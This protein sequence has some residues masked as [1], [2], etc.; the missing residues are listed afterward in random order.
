MN[1]S[2]ATIADLL[3]EISGIHGAASSPDPNLSR[4]DPTPSLHS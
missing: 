3:V 4:D 1:S 2:V